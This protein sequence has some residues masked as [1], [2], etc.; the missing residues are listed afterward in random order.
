MVIKRTPRLEKFYRELEAKENLSYIGAVR[1]YDAPHK[2]TDMNNDTITAHKGFL[3]SGEG[4]EKTK[5]E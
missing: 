5:Y 2:E 3:A 4:C 1:I